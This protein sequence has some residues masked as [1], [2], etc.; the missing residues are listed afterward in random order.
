VSLLG[1][2]YERGETRVTLYQS[3]DVTVA[4][5][6]EQI[7]LPMTRNGVVFDF[8]RPFPCGDGIDDLTAGMPTD[9]RV[10]RA[11]L[12]MAEDPVSPGREDARV[13][14][15][16]ATKSLRHKHHLLKE[17]LY[18]M[19]FHQP[20]ELAGLISTYRLRRPSWLYA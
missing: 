12:R 9:T 1:T 15:L 20:V 5:T 8:R 19:V 2:F 16:C 3:D 6:A 11:Y 7:A 10:P 18:Q 4:R 17:D 13:S 14:A